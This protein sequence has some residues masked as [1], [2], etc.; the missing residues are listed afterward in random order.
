MAPSANQLLI[1][2]NHIIFNSVSQTTLN[3]V[4]PT[5]SWYLLWNN[6]KTNNV[7][8]YK[9]SGK[10]KSVIWAAQP[11]SQRYTHLDLPSHGSAGLLRYKVRWVSWWEIFYLTFGVRWC[12]IELDDDDDDDDDGCWKQVLS[13]HVPHLWMLR[14]LVWVVCKVLSH[15]CF[16]NF[17]IFY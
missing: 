16:F 15:P 11:E 17:G 5:W 8:I 4:P 14:E 1:K 2:W 12:M 3:A 7:F 10:L 9:S 6:N 13:L